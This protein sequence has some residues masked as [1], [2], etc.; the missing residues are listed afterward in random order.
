M[1]VRLHPERL[2]MIRH[3]LPKTYNPAD[4]ED[5]IYRGWEEKGYFTPSTDDGKPPFSIVIPPPNVTG[6]LHMGHAFDETLQD[7]I[8]YKRMQGYSAL[9]LPGTDHA[10]I[11]TQIKV[12]EH[13]RQTE[14]LSRYDPGARDSSSGSGNGKTSTA[15][16][17][18]ANLRSSAP[19]ATG[20]ASAHN[21]RG[22]IPRRARVFVNLY[23]KGL[24]YRG[25]R[26]IN[27]CPDCKTALSDAEVEYEEQ[28]GHFWHIRYPLKDGSGYLEVATTRPE[29]MLGIPPWRSTE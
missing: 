21:G 8:R 24:I 6:Q 9:W 7:I 4:F 27:W 19:P 26:I 3:E 10:G 23:E 17:L 29:T 20:R 15:A 13:L 1:Q 18:S 11:A 2:T 25:Y 12:E 16:G 5:R 22:A 14:G 28:A